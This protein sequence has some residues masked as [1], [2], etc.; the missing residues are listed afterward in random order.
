MNRRHQ[1]CERS[2]ASVVSLSAS[3]ANSA[4]AFSAFARSAASSAA[5]WA[6]SSPPIGSGELRERGM[7]S[8]NGCFG[9][10]CGAAGKAGLRAVGAR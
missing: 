1:G 7:R 10:P 5:C 2:A 6:L 9:L 3:A 8:M 4:I